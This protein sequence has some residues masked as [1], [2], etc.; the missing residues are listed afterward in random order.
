MLSGLGFCLSIGEAV[1]LMC[2]ECLSCAKLSSK[3]A[4]PLVSAMKGLANT[5]HWRWVR[6][7]GRGVEM[8]RA[9]C[10]LSH[11][12]IFLARVSK[13]SR[14]ARSDCVYIRSENEVDAPGPCVTV[15]ISIHQWTKVVTR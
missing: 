1:G 4:W 7:R 12:E 13:S 15:F 14:K 3:P 5:G 8:G 10:G 2:C 11:Y 9:L 6:H